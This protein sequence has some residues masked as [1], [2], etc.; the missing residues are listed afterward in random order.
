MDRGRYARLI[1]K[2]KVDHKQAIE[3]LFLQFG[4]DPGS[5]EGVI[6]FEGVMLSVAVLHTGAVKLH[7]A[8]LFRY[9]KRADFS[10]SMVCVFCRYMDEDRDGHLQLMD[11]VRYFSG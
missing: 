10:G 6:T 4:K 2:M 11:F 1:S 8:V 3:T 5:L 9:W 7:A